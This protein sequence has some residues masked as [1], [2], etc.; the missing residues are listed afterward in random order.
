MSTRWIP[1][2]SGSSSIIDGNTTS[3]Y[4]SAFLLIQDPSLPHPTTCSVKAYWMTGAIT[5]GDLCYPI[6]E[7]HDLLGTLRQ[8]DI[9]TAVS[10]AYG[11]NN[12]PGLSNF[13][14]APGWDT[15]SLTAD[16]L[17]VLTPALVAN[18]TDYTT[19]AYV[20]E[21][22]RQRDY[23][24]P[25]E[26]SLFLAINIIVA[27]FVVDGMSRVG[28]TESNVSELN[29]STV[30]LDSPP[31]L[32]NSQG[33]QQTC[34]WEFSSDTSRNLWEDLLNGKAKLTPLPQ[35]APKAGT[36]FK[37]SVTLGGWGIKSNGLAY[38]LALSVLF[39]YVAIAIGHIIWTASHG[40]ISSNWKSL[41][42]LLVLSQ[43]SPA[44]VDI[45]RNTS[46]GV[47]SHDT[48]KVPVRIRNDS[49]V[50]QGQETL[51]ML[52]GKDGEDPQLDQV[53]KRRKYGAKG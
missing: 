29:Q 17:D 37:Y 33:V 7:R 51:Q 38:Y 6:G 4:P 46:S 11:G 30:C 24:F 43:A 23:A 14:N 45:L 32:G 52:F 44:P 3:N 41:T 9:A 15:V 31:D 18:T 22:L 28:Y 39:L 34:L 26:R 16:W 1:I 19:L 20:L 49:S 5:E 36:M 50:A 47:E 40:H 53:Q 48:L 2:P 42:D 8:P 10:W 13:Q 21:A 35:L 27:S 25:D 12:G